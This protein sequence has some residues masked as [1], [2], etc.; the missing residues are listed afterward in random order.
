MEYTVILVL[1]LF[2]GL[3]LWSKLGN[4]MVTQVSHGSQSL[5][6]TLGSFQHPTGTVN[7]PGGTPTTAGPAASAPCNACGQ[8][9][10]PSQTPPTAAPPLGTKKQRSL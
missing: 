2:G 10:A 1:I 4:Q 3:A 7:E 6:T 8:Q 5:G 9:T